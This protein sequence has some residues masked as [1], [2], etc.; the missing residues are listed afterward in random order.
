MWKSRRKSISEI[1]NI[2]GSDSIRTSSPN[3][4]FT[5]SSLKDV[6]TL[7]SDDVTNRFDKTLGQP[8]PCSATAT[9]TATATA[10]RRLSIFHR[11]HLANKITR[12]FS[13]NQSPNSTKSQPD[14]PK[15]TKS[16]NSTKSVKSD[17]QISIPGAEKRVILYTTSLRV[18][19]P[20]FEAC[21]SVQSILRGFRVSIDERDLSMD[22]RFLQ[23]LQNIMSESGEFEDEDEIDKTKL[24]LQLPRVFIGGKYIG[25]AEEV[26]QLHETGELKKFVERLPAVSG[27]VCAVCGD[28]RFVVCDEC[29]GSRK[30]YSDKGGFRSCTLCNENGLVRCTCC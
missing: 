20:T 10:T 8:S 17:R 21:R 13:T 26:K 1:N 24:Q 28:F 23:E 27:G 7:F 6:E 12:A 11:V 18:V 16:T 3:H 19:R 15:P 30:C 2:N 4:N 5:H 9:P 22:S 25:G 14:S 29:N